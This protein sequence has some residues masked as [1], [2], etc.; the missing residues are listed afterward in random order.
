MLAHAEAM[1][2]RQLRYFLAVVECGSINRA[3]TMLKLTQPSLSHA[4]KALERSVGAELLLRSGAGIRPTEIGLVLQRYARNILR[5]TEKAKAEVSS[6]RGAG[7]GSLAVGALSVFTSRLMPQVSSAFLKESRG[8]E[9]AAYSISDNSDTIMRNIQSA[10]WDLALTL[11]TE[12]LSAPA[13]IDIRL[14]GTYSSRVFCSVSHPL[15]GVRDVTLP[16][17]AQAEWVVTQ[18]G[19]AELQ[20]AE[21]FA[22]L[23][24]PP[25]VRMRVNTI[26]FA[27][28]AA[29][30][31]PF[32][33]IAPIDTMVDE[34]ASGRMVR[35]DQPYFRSEAR[36]ALLHSKLAERTSAMRTFTTLC[37]AY[38]DRLES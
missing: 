7:A 22:P 11:M 17:L 9:I 27:I 12:G 14:L 20:L 1:E 33:C 38:A 13:D 15:A 36:I 5:E 30:A 10:Q 6:M 29:R 23:E 26:N 19:A 4:I 31:H 16:Q 35:V 2:L 3:A 34:I 24:L 25:R 21:L 18:S 37:A 28:S 8:V 32:L